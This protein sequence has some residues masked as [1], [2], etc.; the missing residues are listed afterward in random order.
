MTADDA[1]IRRDI[2][3]KIF[4]SEKNQLNL[5]LMNEIYTTPILESYK[6]TFKSYK[7]QKKNER[8]ERKPFL[9]ISAENKTK[10]YFPSLQVTIINFTDQLSGGVVNEK[11]IKYQVRYVENSLIKL[12]AGCNDCKKA[13]KS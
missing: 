8:V 12:T 3:V 1:P 5:M 2:C 7:D 11:G 10:F 9:P 4:A 6:A 13:T